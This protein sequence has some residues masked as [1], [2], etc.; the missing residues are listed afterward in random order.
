MIRLVGTRLIIPKG[1]TGSFVL[2]VRGQVDEGD[3]A[4]FSVKDPLTRTTVIEKL[5]D[6]NGENLFIFIEHED[7]MN[8][9]AGKYIWDVKIYRSPKYDE[10]GILVD[11]MEI[12]SYYSAFGQPL[13][14]IKEVAKY[15]A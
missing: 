15:Y 2:P 12:D 13:L 14:I 3:V 6:A 9:N 1:D 7:T 8:L 10:D 11:A 5:L 4:V